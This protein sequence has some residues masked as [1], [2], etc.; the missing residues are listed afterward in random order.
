M[1]AKPKNKVLI[2]VGD[3]IYH[4][5]TSG[6]LASDIVTAINVLSNEFI[7]VETEGGSFI[8]IVFVNSKNTISSICREWNIDLLDARRESDRA[9]KSFR[10]EQIGRYVEGITDYLHLKWKENI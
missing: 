2:K 9:T 5:M 1:K 4:I 8:P 6:V 7:H 10:W 3:K